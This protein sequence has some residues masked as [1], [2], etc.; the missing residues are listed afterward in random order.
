VK[1]LKIKKML[2]KKWQFYLSPGLHEGRPGFFKRYLTFSV[3]D[4]DDPF[5]SDPILGG[6]GSG[7]IIPGWEM[8]LKQN[9]SNTKKI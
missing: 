6:S 4:P 7:K 8:N 9:F 5:G 3:I 1:I 2:Y